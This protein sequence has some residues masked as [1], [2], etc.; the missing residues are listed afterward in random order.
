[1]FRVS[2]WANSPQPATV[3][4]IAPAVVTTLMVLSSVRVSF[5]LSNG[6]LLIWLM[7]NLVNPQVLGKELAL[8]GI[9]FIPNT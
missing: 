7:R 9:N 1:M 8:Q 4:L 2:S 6:F 5:R 3:K